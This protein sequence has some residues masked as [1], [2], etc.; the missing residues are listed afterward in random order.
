MDDELVPLR[1]IKTPDEV[2]AIGRACAITDA[3]FDH[4]V[5]FISAGMTEREVAWELESYFRANGSE[6]LAFEPIV[7][8]ERPDWVLVVGDVNS[9]VA[10]AL[11]CAKLGVPVAGSSHA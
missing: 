2:G 7:V 10:C 3:C 1:I 9:T 11:V 4:I 6:G 5:H 8:R